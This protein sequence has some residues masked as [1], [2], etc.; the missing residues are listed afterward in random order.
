MTVPAVLG[1]PTSG[2]ANAAGI[3]ANLPTGHSSGELVFI[4]IVRRGV[5]AFTLPTGWTLMDTDERSVAASH[6]I[7]RVFDGGEADTV[8]LD[9][10]GG[11]N[12]ISYVALRT[13]AEAIDLFG[14]N[15]DG[16]AVDTITHPSVTTT[17]A[18][19]LI[20]RIFA[21]SGLGDTADIDDI[22]EASSQGYSQTITTE[23]TFNAVESVGTD[24]QAGIGA[25][26]SQVSNLLNSFTAQ[27]WGYTVVLYIAALTLEQEGFRWR[28]NDGTEINAT[29]AELQDVN[30]ITVAGEERRLRVLLNSTGDIASDQFTLKVKKASEPLS[31]LKTIN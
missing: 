16:F 26:S 27:L 22:D 9:F 21:A 18:D 19:T 13:D 24:T 14:F 2:A 29:W 20:L 10:G 25:S 11:T 15:Q 8:Q 1:T 12:R 7:H 6:I 3:T 4:C 30:M 23:T 28:N 31:A 17:R 5:G